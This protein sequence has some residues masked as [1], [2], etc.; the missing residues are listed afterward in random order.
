MICLPAQLG[1][2]LVPACCTELKE[3]ASVAPIQPPHASPKETASTVVGAVPVH[4]KSAVTLMHAPVSTP[5][6]V[7]T[8]PSAPRSVVK[9][10]H[11]A[12]VPTQRSGVK[13]GR[14]AP[15]PAPGSAV[16]P[17][18]PAPR[19]VVKP[20]LAA[21]VSRKPV[22]RCPQTRGEGE[23][24]SR[25]GWM[26][27]WPEFD[28]GYVEVAGRATQVDDWSP[29]VWEDQS[30]QVRAV[31][32]WSTGWKG[33][34]SAASGETLRNETR[35]W[36]ETQSHMGRDWAEFMVALCEDYYPEQQQLCLWLFVGEACGMVNSHIYKKET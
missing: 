30:A 16:K 15:V 12:P 6:L 18:S 9:P 17:V 29:P 34:S 23:V 33:S 3:A 25:S 19:P 4:D 20:T 13:P 5:G 27:P 32:D 8:P 11:Y 21:P 2:A 10:K 31:A 28:D 1:P 14:N 7:S 24:G 26:T 36:G 35:T 22:W